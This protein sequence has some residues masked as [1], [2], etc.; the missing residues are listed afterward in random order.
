MLLQ[1]KK[2]LENYTVPDDNRFVAKLFFKDLVPVFNFNIATWNEKRFKI[3]K[4]VK[5]RVTFLNFVM[6]CY[7]SCRACSDAAPS[8]STRP[9]IAPHVPE[10]AE[11]ERSDR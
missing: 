1:K 2:T 6:C 9:P 10:R 8:C 5:F 11:T 7:F 3:S 4:T